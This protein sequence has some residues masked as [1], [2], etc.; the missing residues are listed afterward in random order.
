MATTHLVTGNQ[1]S[2]GEYMMLSFSMTAPGPY[3][4]AVYDGTQFTGSTYV[5][6]MHFTH[7]TDSTVDIEGHDFVGSTSVGQALTVQVIDGVLVSSKK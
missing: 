1:K 2:L 6:T 4:T 7:L 5:M 3:T